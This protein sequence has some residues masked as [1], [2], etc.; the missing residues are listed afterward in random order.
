VNKHGHHCD[1]GPYPLRI[2]SNVGCLVAGSFSEPGLTL[3]FSMG[4]AW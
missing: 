3:S 4:T 2:G 1:R